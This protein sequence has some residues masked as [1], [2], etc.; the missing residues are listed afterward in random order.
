MGALIKW[1]S[2]G[3]ARATRCRLYQDRQNEGAGRANRMESAM[4]T[5]N[6]LWLDPDQ[7]GMFCKIPAF[8]RFGH[9]RIHSIRPPQAGG[10]SARRNGTLRTGYLPAGT[11]L[12]PAAGFQRPDSRPPGT[13]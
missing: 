4:I 3:S 1:V 2:G 11:A 8:H 13:R 7:R 5:Y 9:I 10:P 12:G 6:P